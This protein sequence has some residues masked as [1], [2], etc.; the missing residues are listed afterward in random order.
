L[1]RS[2]QYNPAKGR[3]RLPRRPDSARTKSVKATV[4]T[5]VCGSTL[6]APEAAV[7]RAR[8]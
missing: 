6:D 4:E 1:S 3:S 5:S 7:L 2:I 8:G